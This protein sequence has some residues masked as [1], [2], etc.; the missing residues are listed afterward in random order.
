MPTETVLILAG[1]FFVVA[2]LYTSVGHAGASGYLA[3]MALLGVAP[4][5][6][7]PI[8]LALNI[9]VASF[10]VARFAHAGYFRW[11]AL[12]PFLLGSV[13]LAALGGA[14]RLA[15][16]LYY[17][18]LGVALLLS[19]IVLLWRAYSSHPPGEDAAG[20]PRGPAVI[21]GAA[22]GLLSGLT[23][24]GGGIF[25]SPVI[26]LAGWAGPKHTA[27]ISSPFILVNSTVALLAGSF[28][29][30]SIPPETGWLALAVLAGALLGTWLG[31]KRLSVPGLLT[32]L[33]AVLALAAA[34]LFLTR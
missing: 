16:H 7:R 2:T 28:T 10:T 1:A 8:A 23:G 3:T 20:I 12:W 11:R 26:L 29:W 9:L 32:A 18:V 19:A 13:P 6:M 21:I 5:A 15:S 33:A 22:I 25:L 31:L 4:D 14:S 30:A 34:K 27:G 24:T 17:V